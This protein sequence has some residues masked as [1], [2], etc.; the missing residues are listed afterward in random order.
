M[1]TLAKKEKVAILIPAHN[2]EK[3]ISSTIKAVLRLADKKDVYV[4]DDGSTDGTSKIAKKYF[5]N[6]LTTPNEGKAH[7]LNTGIRHFKLIE[8]YDFIFLMDADSS[9][10]ANFLKYALPHFKKD[11]KKE[12]FCVSGRVKGSTKNWITKYRQWEYQVA[13]LIHKKAQQHLSSILV[14]PGCATIYRSSIFKTQK[15][16]SGTMTEDM[17][18]TFQM[19]RAGYNKMIFESK[20]VV[21]TIDPYTL[22]D[23]AKQ[24]ERWYTGFWQS[25][26]KHDVPWRGQMLDFEVA[27][28]AIEGLYNGVLVAFLGASIIKLSFSGGLSI[29]VTPIL[30]DLFIFFLPSL[31]WS[32]IADKDYSRIL[33]VPH[34]YLLRLLSSVIFIKSYFKGFLSREKTYVW[35][36]TRYLGKEVL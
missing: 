2:E 34:F 15:F 6:I 16:P 14:T 25:V 18:F 17:D 3:V 5:I 32:S 26:R 20:A 24:L 12:I 35:D 30:I 9:P 1:K 7:A 27:V 36:S 19:H 8:K 31:I 29:L 23:Y 11:R 22:G 21:N 4:V 10:R 28:L 13:F 33:F